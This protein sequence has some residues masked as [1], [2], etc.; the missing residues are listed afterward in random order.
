MLNIPGESSD[1]RRRDGDENDLGEKVKIHD[2][3]ELE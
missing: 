3:N 2:Q 1:R